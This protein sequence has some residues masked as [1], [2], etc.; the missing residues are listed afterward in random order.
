MTQP[1]DLLCL[2]QTYLPS[3]ADTENALPLPVARRFSLSHPGVGFKTGPV[4][5]QAGE[6]EKRP[7]ALAGL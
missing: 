6:V 3:Q 4:F 1:C 7:Q 5:T 2:D